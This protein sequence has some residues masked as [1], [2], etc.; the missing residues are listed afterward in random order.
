MRS[1]LILILMCLIFSC[2]HD[3][4]KIEWQNDILVPVAHSDIDINKLFS[5]SSIEQSTNN[6]GLITLVFQDD[7]ASLNLD[8]LLSINTIADEQSTTLDSVT[9]L[10]V[11]ISDTATIGEAITQIPL[12]T[13]LLPNGSTNQIPDL[14]GVASND[15]INVNASQYFETMTLYKGDLIVEFFNGYPTDVSNVSLSLINAT[16]QNLIAEFQFPI[17]YSGTSETDTF[18]V[19]GQTLD[20]NIIAIIHNMDVNQSN[21]P[22]LINYNDAIIT[23]ITVSD[24]G[25]IEAT[26]FFPE[27]Q[28]TDKLAE[29]SF[30]MG[31]AQIK[32]IGIKEG[33]VSINVLSTLPN[34]KIIY[35]IPSLK[36]NGISF[37]TENIV[38]QTINGEITTYE[39]DF[40]GYILD[41][42][43]QD[44]R[45]G[46]D[47]V[48]TIY[49]E[50]YS[51]IDS[52]GEL[53]YINQTDSFYSFIE[54]N[55]IP[56]Y[57]IGYLGQDTIEIG[58]NEKEIKI[59]DKITSGSISLDQ[60]QL[61]FNINNYIGAEG[62]LVFKQLNIQ[63]TN[64]GNTINGGVDVISGNSIIGHEYLIERADLINNT[65]LISPHTT[66]IL[67]DAKNMLEIMP[68]LLTTHLD[69]RINPNG[70]QIIDDFLYPDKP[71][72]ASLNLEIPLNFSTNNL[73]L[74][75]T[76]SFSSINNKN[77]EKLYLTVDNGFPFSANIELLIIDQYDNILDTLFQ[78]TISEG[79]INQDGMIIERSTTT[80]QS[81]YSN[82]NDIKK[83][84]A[85]VALNT[86][87]EDEMIKI[88]D[89]YN[90]SLTLS[91]KIKNNV[92]Q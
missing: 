63:N 92:N 6:E 77:I 15:T 2:K 72:N 41:L 80:L 78:N 66:N 1:L 13:L 88:Y 74:I 29:H 12:G 69:Y 5:D 30:D 44:G 3:L 64:T 26:A 14:P 8:T 83:I 56:E 24:I 40:S 91:V 67:L 22:V 28:I 87:P 34:G 47:T 58:P 71:I 86:I 65:P 38:P 17:I 89:S 70:P 43:G 21:G 76:L 49:T 53:E 59:F 48:N 46:G 19:A 75:D 85:K 73:T 50:S 60:A 31:S 62:A 45:I 23:K 36:K 82:I 54:F 18:S 16:S 84:I 33:T 90:I 42:T 25:I 35:N 51:Y 55:I 20:E 81:S 39:F 10:D 57:A 79:I 7:F 11:V 27:Q 52:T 61:Y 68:N 4:E 37:S 9:F 32:E